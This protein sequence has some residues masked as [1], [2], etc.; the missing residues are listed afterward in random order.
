[1]FPT[2]VFNKVY[3]NK[4]IGNKRIK[5]CISGLFPTTILTHRKA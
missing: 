1:M 4:S 3:C 2:T 5:H